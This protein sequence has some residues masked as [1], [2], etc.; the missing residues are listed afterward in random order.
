[1]GISRRYWLGYVIPFVALVLFTSARGEVMIDLVPV[2][3]PANVSDPETGYGSVAYP[4]L[5]GKYE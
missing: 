5:I 4:Y 2:G 3:N 1:M